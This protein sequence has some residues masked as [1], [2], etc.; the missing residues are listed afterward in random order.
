MVEKIKGNIWKPAPTGSKLEHG[1]GH[2][3]V[4]SP[5]G[6]YSNIYPNGRVVPKAKPYPILPILLRK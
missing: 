3:N 1:G 4:E 6:G 5:G 2:W